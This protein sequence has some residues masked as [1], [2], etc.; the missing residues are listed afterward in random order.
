MKAAQDILQSLADF[1]L[2]ILV[3]AIVAPLATFIMP[4]RRS[5]EEKIARLLLVGVVIIIIEA[6][7]FIGTESDNIVRVAKSYPAWGTYVAVLTLMLMGI[8]VRL[9][10]RRIREGRVTL[11]LSSTS[12]VEVSPPKVNG[13]RSFTLLWGWLAGS[14]VAVIWLLGIA[15]SR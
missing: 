14:L 2:P 6:F 5:R 4:S 11:S 12:A 8:G 3:Y 9:G 1:G 15:Y 10:L 7:F 13:R